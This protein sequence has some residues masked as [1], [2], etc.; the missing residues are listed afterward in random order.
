MIVDAMI[1]PPALQPEGGIG[2]GA[3]AGAAAAGSKAEAVGE[4]SSGAETRAAGG[5]AGA[6]LLTPQSLMALVMGGGEAAP[7]GGRERAGPRVAGAVDGEP[8]AAI[9]APA[10]FTPE[11]DSAPEQGLVSEQVLAAAGV[12]EPLAG[13]EAEAAAAPNQQQQPLQQRGG[14]IALPPDLQLLLREGTAASAGSGAGSG[15]GEGEAGVD[16]L[17]G[18]E[19]KQQT[20]GNAAAAAPSEPLPFPAANG[21]PLSSHSA[22]ASVASPAAAAAAAAASAGSVSLAVLAAEVAAL[23]AAVQQVRWLVCAGSSAAGRV[24]CLCRQQSQCSR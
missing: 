7:G 18:S 14:L 11:P 22:A 3:E 6:P 13:A 2:A 8:A 19:A 20:T 23:Q 15:A 4:V 1:V 24:A 16:Q 5:P 12:S 17:R 10:H 9:H 21:A